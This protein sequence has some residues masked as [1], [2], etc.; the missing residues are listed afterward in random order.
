MRGQWIA[1]LCASLWVCGAAEAQV[2]Q[3]L[4]RFAERGPFQVTMERRNVGEGFTLFVPQ[5]LGANGMRHPVVTWG[6]GTVSTISAY[7]ALL[8]HFASHGFVVV[9][10]ERKMTGSGREMLQGVELVFAENDDPS[11]RF[12][13]KIDPR[14][15]AAGH[16]QGGFGA[17]NAGVD[18]RIVC[19]VPLAGASMTSAANLQGPSFIAV[20]ALDTTVPPNTS[21]LASFRA[22]SRPAIFGIVAGAGHATVTGNGGPFRGYATAFF[23]ANLFGD[24]A[25]RSLFFGE[26]RQCG[27]CNDPSWMIVRNF[28]GTEPGLSQ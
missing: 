14:A 6:V 8:T 27:I 15:C 9:A 28:Q 5:P 11:S 12:F 4:A 18:P 1:V 3:E 2:P 24:R 13:Q 7:T 10:T 25:A 20:G 21:P 26:Q 19:T 16:S 17:T 23:A 22:A